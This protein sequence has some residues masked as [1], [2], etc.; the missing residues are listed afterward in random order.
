MPAP[1]AAIVSFRFAPHDGV[2]VEARKWAW[3]LG[4]LGFAVRWVAGAGATLDVEVPGLAIDASAPPTAAEVRAAVEGCELIVVENLLSLPLNPAALRVVASVL[5]GRATI[6]HHHD[7]PWQRE[8]FVG[9]PPPPDDPAWVHVTIS[10]V[11]RR[12]LEQRGSIAATTIYNRFERPV[13]T[14]AEGT[15]M[16]RPVLLHPTRAIPRKNVPAAVRLAEQ[17]GGTYWLLGP[18]EDGYGPTLESVL[19]GARCPVARGGGLPIGDAYAACDLVVYPST[20]EGFGNPTIESAL[21][22]K[23]LVVGNYPVAR[24]LRGFGFRWFDVD[25]V[26]QVRGALAEPD[27]DLLDHNEA[28]AVEHFSL[29]DLPAAL[30][31]VVE[32]VS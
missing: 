26:Q 10:E 12:E 29:S 2:S 9:A 3:A 4:E 22:R 23:A 19:A 27:Q 24:E 18:A 21:A 28:I 17:V 7:L 30:R 31:P 14:G 16:R 5:A 1:T 15:A 11:S 25:D 13:V 8:R 20:W 6:V 32:R